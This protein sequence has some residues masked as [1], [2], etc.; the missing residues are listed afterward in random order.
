MWAEQKNQT[1]PA[2]DGQGAVDHYDYRED[3]HNYYEQAGKLFNLMDKDAQQRLFENTAR[4]MQGT[5]TLVQK[6]H[7]RHCYLADANYGKGVANALG[8]DIK[9]VDMNDTYGARA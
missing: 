8:I 2:Y 1:E 9:S 3:D 7:I 4:N 6:R 5:T